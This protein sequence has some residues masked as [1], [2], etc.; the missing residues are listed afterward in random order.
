MIPRNNKKQRKI[1]SG[2]QRRRNDN[3]TL[4]LALLR[5]GPGRNSYRVIGD[6]SHGNKL[7]DA[8]PDGYRRVELLQENV[9]QGGQHVCHS[10]LYELL[11]G[12]RNTRR[13]VLGQVEILDSDKWAKELQP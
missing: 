12:G 5:V 4:I 13:K 8:F 10:S 6:L 3:G 2:K 7:S 11:E 9:L 1:V